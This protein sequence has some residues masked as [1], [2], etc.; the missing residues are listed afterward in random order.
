MSYLVVI[1]YRFK[2]SFIRRHNVFDLVV[3]GYLPVFSGQK[4]AAL[5][6]SEVF[7]LSDHLVEDVSGDA[8]RAH[9]TV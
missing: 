7:R 8:Q 9:E 5:V 4:P 2:C 3:V 1:E 6:W